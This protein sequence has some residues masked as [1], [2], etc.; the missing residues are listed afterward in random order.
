MKW[1]PPGKYV[2]TKNEFIVVCPETKALR[3]DD[4]RKDQFRV[5]YIG[6]EGKFKLYWNNNA[7][8]TQYDKMLN[9]VILKIDDSMNGL[10]KSKIEFYISMDQEGGVIL[11][12]WSNNVC[13]VNNIL[14][15]NHVSNVKNP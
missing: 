2:G 13:Q 4:L 9:L 8:I 5:V 1:L 15:E 6:N 11:H 3:L 10:L 7:V 14:C 12:Y